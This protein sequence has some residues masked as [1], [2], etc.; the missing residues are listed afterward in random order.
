MKHTYYFFQS[1]INILRVIWLFIGLLFFNQ[2]AA[3]TDA[4]TFL[5]E[6]IPDGT[7]FAP[8]T[9]FTKTWTFK[10]TGTS[11]WNNTFKLRYVSSTN[12]LLSNSQSD[13]PISGTVAPNGTYT[14]SIPMTSRSAAG[15]YREDWKFING[16][17]TT[18]TS[19]STVSVS[20]IVQT[21][22]AA[23]F[24]SET[25]P[26]GTI[27]APNTAF[28]KTWTFKNTGTS[29]W[30]NTFKLRY[31]SST[32]GLLSNSQSDVPISGTVAPNGTY[33]FSIPMTS[34]SSVGTYRE[35]WKFINGAG[36]TITSF[37]TMSVSIDVITSDAATF[38]SET[39]PDGTDLAPNTAFTKTWTFRNS[40]TST[41]NN[42][43]KL[44]YVSN[45]NGLLSNSQS[46][47]PISGTVAPNGTYTFSIP[48]TS[49]G[50]NGT[51]REDWKFINGAGTTITSFSTV[52]VSIIVQIPCSYT[53]TYP[54]PSSPYCSTDPCPQNTIDP[55]LFY[56][57]ECTSYIAWCMNRD[58]GTTSAPAPYFFT[59]WMQD[60][61]WG[62]AGNWNDNAIQL[63]YT[64]NT[65]P[66][67]G[68][69]AH[70]EGSE[71]GTIGHVAYVEAVNQDGSVNVSEY[72]YSNHIYT[73]RCNIQPPRFIHVPVPSPTEQYYLTM[74]A[75]TGGT[76]SP[77]SAWY[78]SGQSVPINA[79]ADSGYT[80]SNWTGSGSGSYTGTTKS[81]SVTMNGAI[82]ETANFA[83]N[84]YILTVN[85]TNGTVTKNP[86]QAIYD[87]G[88]SIELTA[89]P[90][91]GYHFINWSNGASG[92]ENPL[93]IVMD[94]NKTITANFAINLPFEVSL[95]SPSNLANIQSDSVVLVW[96]QSQPQVL[97]YWIEWSVDSVF[98]SPFIDTTITDTVR[99]IRQLNN[100]QSYWWWVKA[101]N[102]AGAGPFSQSRTFSVSLSGIGEEL[103]IPTKFELNQNFPNP[104]N[105]VTTIRYALP[106]SAR[107]TLSVYDLNGRVVEKLVDEQKVPGHY[108]VQWNA[109]R[110]SAGV[111]FYK[112]EAGDFVEVK[113]CVLVK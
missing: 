76:V 65:T 111:Y 77:S 24:L 49:R 75:G 106:K 8:N 70:W 1:K 102:D 82:T 31:V 16:A 107:V 53:D 78:N 60:G 96:N 37:S 113:K 81:T 112:L 44:R 72:N 13:V 80:F 15:T 73:V 6:T 26:D 48:M 42:T 110:Y 100:N 21:T 90:V 91:T 10:N 68:S 22:D 94:G 18:I 74:S 12:G 28:T 67:V 85:A 38:L 57:R 4:A 34:R 105:P 30:N 95:V 23:T 5:S 104:F 63:G 71:I 51:Y 3:A 103:I 86:D 43:F 46:D 36:T 54:W 59:N 20:I 11:T 101:I 98:S 89:T 61:H 84:T 83:I 35:D 29:T 14:F 58:A 47:V 88:T 9:A 33:T 97:R 19:F 79:T 45:T 17:G 41:W 52:S 99:V 7:V 56:Y 87:H 50:S 66:A 108:S 92:T 40:G 2:I 25:I 62:N 27:F 55:F 32:N 93:T 69:I 64:V 109:E 39:F